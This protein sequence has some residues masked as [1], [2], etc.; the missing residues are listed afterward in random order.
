MSQIEQ[1]Q[2]LVEQEGVVLAAPDSPQFAPVELAGRNSRVR[3]FSKPQ[4]CGR[5]IST[6][7]ETANHPS[8]R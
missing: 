7:L 3:E 2:T 1:W 6:I 8:R 5:Q 4:L